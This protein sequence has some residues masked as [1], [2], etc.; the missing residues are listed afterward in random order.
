MRHRSFL[1]ILV[2]LLVWAGSSMSA[3]RVKLRSGKVVDGTFIGADPK[4]V[5]LLLDNGS[6]AEFDV[7]DVGTVEFTARKAPAPA[8]TA[9]AAA[10]DPAKAPAPV[11]VPSG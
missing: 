6:I 9:A 8:A 4:S 1:F 3:D 10:P 5:R 7:N 2:A 11:T